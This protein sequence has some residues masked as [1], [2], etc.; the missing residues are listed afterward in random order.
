MR[1]YW[2]LVR[3]PVLARVKMTWRVARVCLPVIGD[4]FDFCILRNEP[5]P[6]NIIDAQKEGKYARQ[7]YRPRKASK[8]SLVACKFMEGTKRLGIVLGNILEIS[9]FSN[10]QFRKH[11]E[12]Y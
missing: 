11:V 4:F 5:L 7:S 12:M 6:A 1:A 2:S 3:Y 9:Y 8:P 10:L